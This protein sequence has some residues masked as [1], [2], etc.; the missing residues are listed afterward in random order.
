MFALVLAGEAIFVLPFSV[1]RYFRPTFVDVFQI[2]QFQLGNAQSLYGL[3]AMFAYA[4]GGSL[5]DVFSVRKL[6]AGSLIFTGIGGLYMATIPSYENLCWLYAFWGVTTILPFWSALIR[7]TR[8]WGCKD[9]Q[10][11]AFGLLDGGRGLI[12]AVLATLTAIVFAFLMPD[13]VAGVTPDQKIVA[14]RSVIYTYS[15]TCV[16]AAV[17]IY[18]FLPRP[19]TN[20]R[21]TVE[22][23]I[24]SGENSAR[25]SR[26]SMVR[27]VIAT[28]VI[29]LQALIIIAAYCTFRATDYY[30]QYSVDVWGWSD[31]ESANLGA[32]NTWMRPVAA[33]G[34]GLLADRFK[35]TLIM[36]LGLCTTGIMFGWLAVMTPATTWAGLLWINVLA[37][38]FAA[39]A[40]RGI[41][42]ALL[43]EASI[44]HEMTGTAVGIISFIGYTPDVFM[45]S[46]VG[47]LIN[48]QS[49][50][51]SGYWSLYTG[52]VITSAI[53]IAATL[54]LRWM[55]RGK[56]E[57]TRGS[58]GRAAKEF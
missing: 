39:F 12:A 24:L 36:I 31:V 7:A 47:W 15:L 6:L 58:N 44:P 17:C 8:E 41:Y 29:W 35:P 25:H 9:T 23:E 13:E 18:A 55:T 40:L 14:L 11:K 19:S 2:D 53:G 21:S 50:G 34:A 27:A 4:I 32:F 22:T 42:F 16:L 30:G 46:L 20:E 3:V 10:G 52:L 57:V 26:W 5:A 48:D 28:P 45:P 54:G 33:V 56:S 43:E 38:C 1:T 49:N 51:P 37:A